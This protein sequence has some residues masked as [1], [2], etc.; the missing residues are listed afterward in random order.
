MH[1]SNIK[2][3][4]EQRER[5]RKD[6]KLLDNAD[7]RWKR[8]VTSI[9]IILGYLALGA[10][11]YGIAYLAGW[12][13]FGK[14][15]FGYLWLGLMVVMWLGSAKIA[16]ALQ[17][18][19]PADRNNPKHLRGIRLAERA[20][21]GTGYSPP[22]YASPSPLGNAFATGPFPAWAV[23]AFTE[24]LLDIEDMTDDEIWAIMC[25]EA[26]HVL[27][28][29]VAINSLAGAISMVFSL[30][31]DRALRGV[32]FPI[33]GLRRVAGMQPLSFEEAQP[34]KGFLSGILMNV[35]F[36]F[37]FYLTSTYTRIIQFFIVRSAESQADAGAAAMT[38]KPCLL[39]SALEK[40]V[41]EA[42]KNRP[43]GWAEMVWLSTRLISI[44]DPIYDSLQ[45][46][47]QPQGVWEKLKAFWK[48]LQLSHPPVPVRRKDLEEMWGDKCPTLAS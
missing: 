37:I 29:H 40:L 41:R 7:I 46:D 38:E 1:N 24:G 15:G 28:W 13:V 18:A 39:V 23:V 21:A 42:Q 31:V 17:K 48:Y 6:P 32:L 30:I 22:I 44:V 36:Y 2:L 5:I 9:K 10:S 19:V 43:T 4:A 45:P 3:S 34:Q 35:V 20:F 26:T 16:V 12:D 8:L 27:D 25:H 14:V 11:I 33:N 47:P